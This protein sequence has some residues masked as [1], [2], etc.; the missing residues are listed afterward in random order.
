MTDYA[1]A[2]IIR[3]RHMLERAKVVLNSVELAVDE[4]ER[5]GIPVQAAPG[6][7]LTLVTSQI[8]ASLAKLD[9]ALRIVGKK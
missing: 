9:L 2:E 3:L 1:N 4:A 6:E 7:A 8:A 5:L